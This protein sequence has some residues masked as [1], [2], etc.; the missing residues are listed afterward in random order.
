MSLYCTH[1]EEESVEESPNKKKKK[2]ET[3]RKVESW[4]LR[5]WRA[6]QGLVSRDDGGGQK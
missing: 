3:L 4:H 6:K 2:K 1:K 5:P